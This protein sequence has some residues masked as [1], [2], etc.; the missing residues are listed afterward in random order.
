MTE[1]YDH[2]TLELFQELL[3]EPSPSGFEDQIAALIM[4]KLESWGYEPVTDAAGNVFV[5]FD[6]QPEAPLVCYAAHMDEIGFM[7]NRIEADG[8]LRAIRH[9]GLMPWKAGEGPVEILT[10]RGERLMGVLSFGSTHGP[11]Q[12]PTWE[13]A[14]IMTGL[15]P[16]EL[17][18]KGV[19]PGSPGVLARHVCQPVILGSNDDPL[20]GAWTF[21]DR[22]G[23]A[24]LLRALKRLKDDGNDPLCPT[25]VAFTTREEVGGYG[26]RYLAS[27]HMP[28]IFIAVDGAPMTAETDLKLDGRPVAW[29]KDQLGPYDGQLI[30]DLIEIGRDLEI[31]V[32][33]ATYGSNA[34]DA[35]MAMTAGGV[36]RIACF[37]HPR[38]NSHGFEVTRLSVFDNM[39][40]ILLTFMT[41]WDGRDAD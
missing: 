37:G 21:D 9:G 4:D 28:D 36:G 24:T 3:E 26:A 16:E 13:S 2:P 29:A 7:V 40:E 39:L 19:R 31:G 25:I 30:V 11:S 8:R 5:M 12:T 18:E 34:S 33:T 17:N 38:E 20:V 15:T 27:L 32:Q 22:L 6:G 23:C 41:R 10:D 1:P 35:S 14:S